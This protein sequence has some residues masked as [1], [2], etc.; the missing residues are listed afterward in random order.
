MSV[1]V[2]ELDLTLYLIFFTDL[3]EEKHFEEVNY[4][5]SLLTKFRAPVTSKSMVEAE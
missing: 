4:L 3:K 5:L 2:P 1:K